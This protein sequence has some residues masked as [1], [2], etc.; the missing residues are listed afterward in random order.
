[1]MM[2]EHQERPNFQGTGHHH[3]AHSQHQKHRDD[4]GEGE[5]AEIYTEMPH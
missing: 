4:H 5:G 1:M 3:I 2:G